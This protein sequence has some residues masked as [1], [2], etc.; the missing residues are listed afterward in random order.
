MTR[1][2]SFWSKPVVAAKNEVRAPITEYFI[3]WL[4]TGY[5]VTIIPRRQTTPPHAAALTLR[6][7]ALRFLLTLL[8]VLSSHTLSIAS[9]VGV[10]HMASR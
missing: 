4:S 9:A 3:V 8:L 1:F 2:K 6:Y 10:V 7:V 5:Y